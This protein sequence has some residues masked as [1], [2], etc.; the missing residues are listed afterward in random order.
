MPCRAVI[1]PPSALGFDCSNSLSR[2]TKPSVGGDIK[3][4]RILKLKLKLN[5]NLNLNLNNAP[6]LQ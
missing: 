6:I 3:P 4:L 2:A 1:F 5:L